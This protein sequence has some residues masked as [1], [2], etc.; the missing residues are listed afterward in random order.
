MTDVRM[1]DILSDMAM[2]LTGTWLIM[3]ADN[4]GM[5]LSSW[6][7]PENGVH[8]E[9]FGGFIQLINGTINAPKKSSVGFTRLD[10]VIFSTPSTYMMIKPI[11]D[12]ACFLI[13]NAPRSVPLGMIRMACTSFAPRLEQSIPGREP[14]PHNDG[15]EIIVFETE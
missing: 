11:A 10:D 3:V 5:L 2:G 6:E 15:K 14:L 9:S 1:K 4:D 7:S 13:V 12:G 8:P